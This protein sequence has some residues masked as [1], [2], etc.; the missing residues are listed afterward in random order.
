VIEQVTAQVY[1]KTEKKVKSPQPLKRLDSFLKRAHVTAA[2]VQAAAKHILATKGPGGT[3]TYAD[4][5]ALGYSRRTAVWVAKRLVGLR[6]LTKLTDGRG[7]RGREAVF[8]ICWGFSPKTVKTKTLISK[9]IKKQSKDGCRLSRRRPSTKSLQVRG[10]V[11]QPSPLK[12]TTKDYEGL[13]A[14]R[15]RLVLGARF[16]RAVMQS[17]RLSLEGWSLPESVRHAL[18]GLVGNRIDG[19]SLADARDLVLRVTLLRG[20]IERRARAG[21]TPRRICA[22]VAG[23]LAGRQD[24][25]RSKRAVLRRTAELVKQALDQE[26]VLLEQ[27]IAGVKR[28]L[29]DRESEYLA[30]TCCGRCGYM[31]SAVEYR[32]GYRDDGTGTLNC[33]GWARVKI[34]DLRELLRRK[35]RESACSSCGGS[36]RDGNVGGMCWSCYD[37]SKTR[38][39]SGPAMAA[40]L[41]GSVLKNIAFNAADLPSTAGGL[42]LSAPVFATSENADGGVSRCRRCGIA[43]SWAYSLCDA[44]RR[45]MVR[46]VG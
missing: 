18:E 25:T 38:I 16:Y 9:D 21:A 45:A 29:T 37:K 5:Q 7:G 28:F 24:F 27:R 32:T 2:S 34:E 12:R 41:I 31:H 36:L 43:G 17:T 11:D 10:R 20:E 30:R 8:Q 6:I 46:G 1:Q 13:E 15:V 4:I 42:S 44:C 40:D 39:V 26:P 3:V 33:F 14:E 19:M 35:R 22:F 23:R